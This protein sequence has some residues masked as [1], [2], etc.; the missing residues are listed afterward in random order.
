MTTQEVADKLVEMCRAGKVEEVKVDLFTEDTTSIEPREGALP[1]ETKGLLAIQQKANLFISMVDEF[2][3]N[4]ISDPI[5]AG[6]YFS[7]AWVTDLKMK[8]R[9]R[10]TMSELCVYEVREGKILSERFFY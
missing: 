4:T 2:Y 10:E 9:E 6:N 7:L 5:V 8:G 3:S 1:L